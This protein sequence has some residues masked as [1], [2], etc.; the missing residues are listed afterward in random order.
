[1]VDK[2]DFDDPRSSDGLPAEGRNTIVVI[3]IDE[4]AHWPRLH[5]AVTDATG[6]E[7][8]FRGLG[9]EPLDRPLLDGDATRGAIMSLLLDTLPRKLGP[10][11][12]VVI[13]FAGH[14]RAEEA[15]VGNT[16]VETGYIAPVDA[17]TGS[18]AELIDVDTLLGAA[19]R[20]PA[21][22]VLVFLDSCHSG[23]ALGG[24]V[25]S[26]RSLPGP[27]ADLDRRRSRKV[28]T[29]ARG[30]QVASDGGPVPGHSLFTGTLIDGLATGRADRDGNGVVTSNELGLYLEQT[31][32]AATDSSQTPDFG[33]FMLD[34]RGEMI[35]PLDDATFA[36]LRAKALGALQRGPLGALGGL[37][38]QM[39]SLR[40]DSP[41]TLYVQ[42]RSCLLDGDAAGAE[43]AVATLHASAA[44][45][46]VEH[47]P[48]SR[49]DVERIV[50]MLSFARRIAGLPEA[51]VDLD[52]TV[53]TGPDADHLAPAPRETLDGREVHVVLP[54]A[55]A[56]IRAR[57]THAAARAWIYELSI[58]P[59][60]LLRVGPLLD[61]RLNVDGLPPGEEAA[62]HVFK[63]GGVPGLCEIRVLRASSLRWALLAAGNTWTRRAVAPPPDQ[64]DDL[65]RASVWLRVADPRPAWG[66][67]AT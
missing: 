11:D 27:L 49:S 65:R 33:S 61:N 10:D 25:S 6:V 41:A 52:L 21:R 28:I 23:V 55:L 7:K 5:N 42:Y 30:D 66:G 56:L 62:G 63:P 37:A 29:S 26:L 43:R 12:G 14:G 8:L 48:L 16:T 19:A 24:S 15:V 20:L 17:R 59:S 35:I 51:P 53:L 4:Y 50:A 60:G 1:M 46:D 64:F 67:R 47:V 54:G 22:H 9:F 57:N 45:L 38:A 34:D 3:G 58:E 31:V 18:L 32:S 44:P 40:P 13:F 2:R 36:V 39:A